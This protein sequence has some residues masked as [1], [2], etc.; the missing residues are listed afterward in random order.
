MEII[1]KKSNVI[2]QNEPKKTIL[3]M[4]T[5]QHVK[6]RSLCKEGLCGTCKVKKISGQVDM[7]N[8]FALYPN[9]RKNG[10]ILACIAYAK[11]DVI[12]DA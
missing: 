9:E 11:S 4:A 2:V 12:I 7:K 8:A 3:E 1:F 5:M 10:V 6:I